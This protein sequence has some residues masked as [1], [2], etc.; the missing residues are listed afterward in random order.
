M[1]LLLCL[2]LLLSYLQHLVLDAALAP[3][4]STWHTGILCPFLDLDALHIVIAAIVTCRVAVVVIQNPSV[5]H[6][7]HPERTLA[8]V[9]RQ[10]ASVV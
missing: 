7:H 9:G 1:L 6:Q 10:E 8:D 4:V 2:F 3:K 5:A